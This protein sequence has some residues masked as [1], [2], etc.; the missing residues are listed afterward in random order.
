MVHSNSSIIISNRIINNK[1]LADKFLLEIFYYIISTI[2]MCHT[3]T[4]LNE[5]IFKVNYSDDNAI[6][7]INYNKEFVNALDPKL[8]D[9][10]SN[11]IDIFI[12][13]G[14][15]LLFAIIIYIIVYFALKNKLINESG[16]E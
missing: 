8:K 12:D 3:N 5:F 9:K 10:L 4:D 11:F 6:W 15:F 14:G 16:K 7:L 1:Y 2:K 13:Y